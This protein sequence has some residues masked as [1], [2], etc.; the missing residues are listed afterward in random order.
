[1][2]YRATA[3]NRIRIHSIVSRCV[4]V[5]IHCACCLPCAN[6]FIIQRAN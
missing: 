2:A 4:I 6:F 5:Y 3:S 1:M